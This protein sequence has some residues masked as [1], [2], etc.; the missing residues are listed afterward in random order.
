MMV[1]GNLSVKKFRN[2]MGLVIAQVLSRDTIRVGRVKNEYNVV[3]E[4]D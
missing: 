1:F 4:Y 3:A 2:A